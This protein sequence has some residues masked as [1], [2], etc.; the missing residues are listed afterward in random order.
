M[1]ISI[2][3]LAAQE[4]QTFKALIWV[5]EDVFE[6]QDF[7]IPPDAHLQKLLS[8][9]EF[10]VFVAEIEKEVVA[11]LTA[12]TLH[13][14]YAVRPLVYIFDLAVKRELQRQGIGKKLIA[15]ITDHCRD[16]G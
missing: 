9:P 16:A 12:Y 2:R 14:Y 6:M 1:E 15:A 8:N 11:G 5:F 10:Y 3:Q 4:L 13:Q 7:R